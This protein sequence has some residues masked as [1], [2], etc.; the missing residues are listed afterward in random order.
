MT[1][2][3][4]SSS[5]EKPVQFVEKSKI[6]TGTDIGSENTRDKHLELLDLDS[7]LRS[8]ISRAKMADFNLETKI[9][10]IKYGTTQ[11]LKR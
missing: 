10:A 2:H 8:P 3:L 1:R 9:S 4:K 5:K 7:F 6:K 11:T